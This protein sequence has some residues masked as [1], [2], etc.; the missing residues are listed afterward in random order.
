MN[1]EANVRFTLTSDLVGG[2]V[3][4]AVVLP[5]A[6]LRGEPCPVL[7]ALHGLGAKHDCF[8]EM[9]RLTAY[10]AEHPMILVTFDGRNAAYVDLPH[11][12]D[13]RFTS[14]FFEILE[15]E[16]SRRFPTDGRMA[17]TGFSMGGFGAMHLLLTAP[18]R[19]VA[20][21]GL[22]S[23]TCLF[24]AADDENP[25][26]R[27]WVDGLVGPRPGSDAVRE[28]LQLAPRF[29][30]A[31]KEGV[32]FPPILLMCGTEDHLLP[33]NREFVDA[34]ARV[35]QALVEELLTPAQRELPE[36]DKR[37]LLARIQSERCVDFEYRET[38]GGHDWPY[39]S[40]HFDA[41]AEFHWR[42]FES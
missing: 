17:V 38:S 18:K 20:A 32:K 22:S 12:E 27:E 30:R 25:V 13:S 9:L 23:A 5:P 31:V 15:P 1:P 21:S 26:R 33:R 4:V 41:A 16:I 42:Q 37:P 3:P 35:N 6:A 19:F 39:W 36:K 2:E 28:A 8:L 40:T 7:Y 34:L 10:A 24:T 29:A 11:R 14:F